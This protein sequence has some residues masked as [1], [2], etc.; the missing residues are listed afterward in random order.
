[1]V[2]KIVLYAIGVILLL[3]V[4]TN[5]MNSSQVT[6]ISSK[7]PAKE[8]IARSV[9]TPE[10]TETR[11]DKSQQKVTVIKAKWGKNYNFDELLIH[12]DLIVEGTISAIQQTRALP[13]TESPVIF[14]DYELKI[15]R[16]L[17]NPPGFS[18][19]SIIV[20]QSGG[21]LDSVTQVFEGNEPFTLG[22]NVLLFLKDISDDP[23]HTPEGHTKYSV[24]LNGGRFKIDSDDKLETLTKGNPVYDG[25]RGKNKGALES[26]IFASLPEPSAYAKKSAN[27]FLIVEGTVGEPSSRLV[28]EEDTQSV[29]T[30]YP[31]EVEH[32]I[33]DELVTAQN[34]ARKTRIY[35]HVPVNEGDVITIFERGGVYKDIVQRWAWSWGMKSG[36]RMVLFLGAFDCG[37]KPLVC[38]EQELNSDKAMYLAAGGERFLIE[39]DNT[40]KAVT[41]NFISRLYD[42]KSKGVLEQDLITARVQLDAEMEAK[43][44]QPMQP[45]E[46]PPPPLPT[47]IPTPES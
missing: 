35:E 30:V 9:K 10:I 13:P 12:S 38:T 14:T 26:D 36:S 15:S 32:V 1:M 2:N 44:N 28:E 37:D 21:T 27:A 40:L 3:F 16:V 45:T 23:I 22:E 31:F 17:K 8:K 25:Y 33:Y 43:M 4:F 5:C 24:L 20:A 11:V 41:R 46:F 29:F 42:G 34:A 39:S 7:K 6:P 47:I 19:A 18:D